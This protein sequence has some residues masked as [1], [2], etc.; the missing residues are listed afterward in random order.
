[1]ASKNSLINQ[2]KGKK[3]VQKINKAKICTPEWICDEESTLSGFD[4]TD[5]DMDQYLVERLEANLFLLNSPSKFA[6]ADVA[7]AAAA[8][9]EEAVVTPKSKPGPASKTT[10]VNMNMNK[11][12]ITPHSHTYNPGPKHIYLNDE[13]ALKASILARKNFS[14]KP[15]ISF[16]SCGR[17]EGEYTLIGDGGKRLYW[18]ERVQQRQ[19]RRQETALLASD[20]KKPCLLST[21]L[22]SPSISA[23]DKTSTFMLLC[24]KCQRYKRVR[25]DRS[26]RIP[27]KFVCSPCKHTHCNEEVEEKIR[28]VHGPSDWE[29]FKKAE[30]ALRTG[31]GKTFS[32]VY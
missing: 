21:S 17:F 7:A 14:L 20:Q 27:E 23:I 31:T 28:D 3:N 1:M 6:E 10:E 29:N 25:W 16:E 19:P 13:L 4:D 30:A 26:L 11:Y 8:A 15:K 2:S 9:T 12:F 5:P 24:D 18:R 32:Q 22:C